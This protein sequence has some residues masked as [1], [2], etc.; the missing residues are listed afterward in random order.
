MIHH[1]SYFITKIYNFRGDLTTYTVKNINAAAESFQQLQRTQLRAEAMELLPQ[2]PLTMIPR[3]IYFIIN[4][5]D[6][7]DDLTTY[8]V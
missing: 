2:L 4:I 7:Q 8:V 6:F 3:I 5:I 1:I